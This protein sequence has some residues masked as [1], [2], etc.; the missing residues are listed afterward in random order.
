MLRITDL[1][2]I[3]DGYL[4]EQFLTSVAAIL[5][6]DHD[7]KILT[8]AAILDGEVCNFNY[9]PELNSL[10]LENVVFPTGYIYII[11]VLV[12]VE[13]TTS[14]THASSSAC[15]YVSF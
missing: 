12:R 4:V 13:A 2:M 1:F 3:D 11:L 7:K 9:N 6:Q 8:V 5:G 14:I 15:L 10:A